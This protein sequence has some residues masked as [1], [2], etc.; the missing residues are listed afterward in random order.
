MTVEKNEPKFKMKI[1]HP[2]DEVR[3]RFYDSFW[4]MFRDRFGD[5]DEVT[6]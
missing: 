4:D 2:Y 6:K 3:Y 1:T 5:R